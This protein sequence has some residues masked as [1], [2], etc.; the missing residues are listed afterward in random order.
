MF[1]REN[2]EDPDGEPLEL[3][4]LI[5]CNAAVYQICRFV[6]TNKLGSLVVLR[7]K[8]TAGVIAH[9]AVHVALAI[10][11]ELGAFADPKNQEPFTYLVGFIAD[12]IYRVNT[13]KN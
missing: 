13:N 2:F 5:G 10:F 9:E 8:L 3:G 11:E 6:Q 12:C 1:I 7:E 4:D